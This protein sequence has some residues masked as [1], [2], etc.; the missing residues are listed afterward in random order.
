[1]GQ[2]IRK[3]LANI[4][5]KERKKISIMNYPSIG[6][7]N[8]VIQ[9]SGGNAFRTLD[10]INLIPSRTV[11]IKVYLFGSGAFAAVFKATQS[12]GMIGFA[13]ALQS[14]AFAVTT[15]NLAGASDAIKRTIAE[16]G[17]VNK[18]V[19]SPPKIPPN[20]PGIRGLKDIS[21]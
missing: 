4:S 15:F 3:S 10:G 13:V 7:Y 9:K 2:S 1:L 11:P 14:G 17:R 16:A 6:E 20:S 12:G 8:Q 18:P 19:P 21:I 5:V